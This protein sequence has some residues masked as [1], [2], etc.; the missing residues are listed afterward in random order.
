[1]NE[2]GI[3]CNWITK[4]S[5]VMERV[6]AKFKTDDVNSSINKALTKISTT[7]TVNPNS[8]SLNQKLQKLC[9]KLEAQANVVKESLNSKEDLSW[10]ILKADEINVRALSRIGVCIKGTYSAAIAQTPNLQNVIYRH[11][12]ERHFVTCFKLLRAIGK[13]KYMQLTSINITSFCCK[14]RN[15]KISMQGQLQQ[16]HA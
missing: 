5:N 11:A 15:I 4:A 7:T 6:L 8:N 16:A 13:T 12:V 2:P 1:M 10:V 9:G 3:L 14:S